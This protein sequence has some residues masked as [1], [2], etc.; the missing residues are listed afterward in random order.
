MVARDFMLFAAFLVQP[1]P[2]AAA[3]HEVV[4]DL[5]LEHR[6]DARDG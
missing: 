4:A 5:H 6:A 2:A 1:R 3:L